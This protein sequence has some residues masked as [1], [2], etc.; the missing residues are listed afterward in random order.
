MSVLEIV[1]TVYVVSMIMTKHMTVLV[2]SPKCPSG[3]QIILI[4]YLH[5]TP[6]YLI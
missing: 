4:S 2:I 5:L 1:L 6:W 3:V